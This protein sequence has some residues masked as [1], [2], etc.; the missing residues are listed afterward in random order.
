[1][2]IVILFIFIV[3]AF[4]P[5]LYIW[6]HFIKGSHM[7]WS[8][9]HWTPFILMACLPL[10]ALTDRGQMFMIRTFITLFM[11]I[12]VPKLL[13]VG[14]MLIGRALSTLLPAASS[15]AYLTGLG[16][17]LITVLIMLY[18]RCKGWKRVQVN[19]IHLSDTRLPGSFNEY[20]IVQLSDFHI[21]TYTDAPQTVERI[22]QLV[23]EQQPDIIVFTGDLVNTSPEEI[24]PFISILKKMKARDGIYSILGN[25]DY[26]TY[27]RHTGGDSAAKSLT[28][29]ITTERDS[30]GWDLLLNEHRILHRGMDSIALIGVENDGRPPFP[31]RANIPMAIKGLDKDLYKIML[32]HDPSHWK[33]SILEKTDIP[34]TLSGHTHAMQL[35]FGSFS[36]SKWL[37]PEWEGLYTKGNQRLFVSTGTGSNVPF[38]LGAWPEI[39]VIHLHAE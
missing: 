33:R 12:V 6:H 24:L 38:R 18:G 4:L 39:T 27:H 8:I 11:V 14:C 19:T 17:A 7:L 15:V 21:G 5:D 13:F 9:L 30:L 25:H 37:Y 20:R 35:R 23:N 36:P 34:L 29:L 16:I 26:C 10:L 22:V 2:F 31:T 28:R 32:S 1:M 3:L